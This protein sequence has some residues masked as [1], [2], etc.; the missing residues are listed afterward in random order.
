MNKSYTLI[1]L[2]A[3]TA[4]LFGAYYI[5][6]KDYTQNNT[7]A[8]TA[9]AMLCP[10]GSYVGRSGPHCEF[11]CGTTSTSTNDSEVGHLTG[12]VTIS[13]TC[14]VERIPPEPQCAAKGYSIQ[15]LISSNNFSKQIGSDVNGYFNLFIPDGTYSLKP[16]TS[17]FYPRCSQIDGVVINKNSTTT[18][19]INCDSGIR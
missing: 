3:L 6:E 12:R 10:D 5:L 2:L 4:A 17:N 8:C 1:I 19:N 9:D 11:K 14:P 7:I 18:A 15:I 16:I 13:P